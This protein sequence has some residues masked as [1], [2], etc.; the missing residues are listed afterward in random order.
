MINFSAIL[1]KALDDSA[2]EQ[3]AVLSYSIQQNFRAGGR[4]TKWPKIGRK[5][6][7]I[8]QDTGR[9][10]NSINVRAVRLGAGK[11]EIVAETNL[12]YAAIHQYGGTITAKN[13]GALAIPLTKEA[14]DKRPKEFGKRLFKKK[15]KDG[16][17][18]FLAE[19]VG[20]RI[21]NHYV[22]KKMVT[23][24][25]RPFILVQTEDLQTFTQILTTNLTDGLR[26]N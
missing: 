7:A 16:K 21:V 24:P 15:S 18:W 9:L 17:T 8:L 11:N 6:G 3:G 13:A 19:A 25:P 1:R 22:L 14:R 4:P 23:I 10:R 26:G 5:G 20:E 2:R 12:K